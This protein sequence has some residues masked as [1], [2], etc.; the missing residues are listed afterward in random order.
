MKNCVFCGKPYEGILRM[1]PNHV[2]CVRKADSRMNSGLCAMCGVN[3][4]EHDGRCKD[5]ML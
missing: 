3:P 4:I 5:C 2:E 1:D